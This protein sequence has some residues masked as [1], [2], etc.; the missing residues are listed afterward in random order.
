MMVL[1]ISVASSIAR[2]PTTTRSAASNRLARGRHTFLDD[3]LGI[4]DLN[5]SSAEDL[6]T[7]LD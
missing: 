3:D 5:Y 1:D 6:L 4:V 2:M 7:S